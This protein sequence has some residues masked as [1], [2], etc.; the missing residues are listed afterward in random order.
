MNNVALALSAI[1]GAETPSRPQLR[2]ISKLVLKGHDAEELQALPIP[3]LRDLYDEE[4]PT[5]ITVS[6]PHRNGGT[7]RNTVVLSAS[8]N[9]RVA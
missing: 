6:M 9:K 1:N 7:T 4:F 3:E 2:F 8:Q 5:H